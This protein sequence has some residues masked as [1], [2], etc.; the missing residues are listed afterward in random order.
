MEVYF[1]GTFPFAIGHGLV[2]R[3]YVTIRHLFPTTQDE[4]WPRTLGIMIR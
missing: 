4:D 2:G 1:G 3:R